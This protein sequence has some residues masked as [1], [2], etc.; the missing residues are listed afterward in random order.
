MEEP[1]A[2]PSK[3]FNE[4][5]YHTVLMGRN[6][7]ETDSAKQ[8]ASLLELLRSKDGG[9]KT[10]VLGFLKKENAASLLMR[11]ISESQNEEDTVT[12]IS[13]CWE[14]G[15]NFIG[16]HGFF[17]NLALHENLAITL[18]AL[19][20]LEELAPEF[21]E[22]D[23]LSISSQFESEAQSN[24]PMAPLIKEFLL[25]RNRESQTHPDHE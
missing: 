20:V 19:T 24:S 18:E 17:A 8:T 4:Q 23:W 12:L 9:L 2:N 25:L 10:E 7:T 5:E 6:D 3:Y 1:K 21:N 22:T 13:T 16:H 11:L 14:S 15:I